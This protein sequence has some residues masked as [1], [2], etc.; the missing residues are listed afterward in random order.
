MKILK[1]EIKRRGWTI[2]MKDEMMR[3]FNENKENNAFLF[4]AGFSRI[5]NRP[6]LPVLSP[7]QEISE[8]DAFQRCRKSMKS[9]QASLMNGENKN[10][11]HKVFTTFLAVMQE[12]EVA[13]AKDIEEGYKRAAL[14]IYKEAAR[15]LQ[16]AQP[17][18]IRYYN[19]EEIDPIQVAER[20]LREAYAI[21]DYFQTRNRNMQAVLS[22]DSDLIRKE[23]TAYTR[24]ALYL[25]EISGEVREVVIISIL[26]KGFCQT[27]KSQQDVVMKG[28]KEPPQVID[29]EQTKAA[30]TA[31]PLL[32]NK[33]SNLEVLEMRQPNVTER[34]TNVEVTS[35]QNDLMRT[36]R[37]CDEN[38]P[39]RSQVAVEEKAVNKQRRATLLSSQPEAPFLVRFEHMK[40]FESF[41][42]TEDNNWRELKVFRL[43]L[44]AMQQ[45]ATGAGEHVSTFKTAS[46]LFFAEAVLQFKFYQLYGQVVEPPM[47]IFIEEKSLKKYEKFIDCMEAM[48][49]LKEIDVVKNPVE[50]GY[51]SMAY[52]KA[53]QQLQAAN[54]EEG[55]D[56]ENFLCGKVLINGTVKVQVSLDVITN[57]EVWNHEP[58]VVPAR[59]IKK[60]KRAN[61][62]P[63][64][65]T[66]EEE[67]SGSGN[68]ETS[69]NK[70]TTNGPKQSANLDKTS[71]YN[72]D[73]AM[74]PAIAAKQNK[75]VD[76]G[77]L[78]ATLAQE[79]TASD[80]GDFET[81]LE[82]SRKKGSEGVQAPLAEEQIASDRKN[83]KTSLKKGPEKNPKGVRAALAEEHPA[84]DSGNSV[85]SL[86]KVTKNNSE[87]V[88][89]THTEE[90]H[91]SD[92]GNPG[93]SFAKVQKKRL[94][95][96]QAAL[97]E[98]HPSS[99]DKRFKIDL[100]K[101][102][103]QSPPL[104]TICADGGEPTTV[105]GRDGKETLFDDNKAVQVTGEKGPDLSDPSNS[106]Q[107]ETSSCKVQQKFLNQCDSC[108]TSIACD[109]EQAAVP[110]GA[111]KQTEIVNLEA[112]QVTTEKELNPSSSEQSAASLSKVP[113]KNL[114]PCASFDTSVT[115]NETPVSCRSIA[116]D[117]DAEGL[118][119]QVENLQKEISAL[120]AK[121]QKVVANLRHKK[122]L[123][124]EAA[125][126][127][128]DLAE[129]MRSQEA[130]L[131]TRIASLRG[132]L[133][134]VTASRDELKMKLRIEKQLHTQA[135][136]EKEKLQCQ[137][138]QSEKA[139][140]MERKLLDLYRELGNHTGYYTWGRRIRV[141]EASLSD[142]QSNVTD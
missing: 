108:D 13:T 119:L 76:D 23:F 12:L 34:K 20:K 8:D 58:S 53:A 1:K 7:F 15:Q 93:A 139:R 133:E 112:V 26:S 94:E 77:A 63:V 28:E 42:H 17:P 37:S 81:S 91:A 95:G 136:M 6:R 126:K 98:E 140:A 25:K 116:A 46:I 142:R 125:T 123:L 85:A 22:N 24:A 9:L 65:A 41:L 55:C 45:L 39:K 56:D 84:S 97:A 27:T 110:V 115:F 114:E 104:N 14:A 80:S 5:V 117:D 118:R 141:L 122:S 35:F 129:E 16:P 86:A 73:H 62:D 32:E 130:S 61:Q 101:D 107:S 4:Y 57:E 88:Q 111:G 21:V 105:P 52:V 102:P 75:L 78:Q 11:T 128:K 2:E 60:S 138:K 69:L 67:P 90:H 64:R 10:Q 66:S 51:A 109:G 120:Q 19:G 44:V 54:E 59:C 30:V 99:D 87:G 106:D 127:Y 103:A 74:I 83:L 124:E 50:F 71:S 89:E 38:Q 100:E 135:R 33:P 40:H 48:K 70:E 29:G 113:Q 47:T 68:F 132:G 36:N 49:R 134:N 18:L 131:H 96:V 31:N 82:K 3:P 121:N 43:F 92:S 137:L 79:Y 72:D